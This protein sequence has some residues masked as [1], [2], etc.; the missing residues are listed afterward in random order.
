MIR[1]IVLWYEHIDCTTK[2]TSKS[3]RW[4]CR[5]DQWWRY[6]DCPQQMPCTSPHHFCSHEGLLSRSCPR[7][8]NQRTVRTNHIISLQ[9]L[10][11]VILLR[12]E[13]QSIQIH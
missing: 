12:T 5:H 2:L 3:S 4:V 8:I 11:I 1:Q 13:Q 6:S 7:I 10:L 9:L